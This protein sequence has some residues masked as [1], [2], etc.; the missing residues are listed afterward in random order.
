MLKIRIFALVDTMKKVIAYLLMPRI[1]NVA[2]IE[3]I[4][5]TLVLTLWWL[6][7]PVVGYGDVLE[8]GRYGV[9]AQSAGITDVLMPHVLYMVS[10]ASFWHLLGNI[11]VLWLV[12]GRLFLL[13]ALA[14][15]FVCSWLPGVGSIW[16]IVNNEPVALTVG[17]SGVLFAI[18]GNKWGH[19]CVGQHKGRISRRGR[20]L[21][22]QRTA[23]SAERLKRFCTH[24]LP[25][26][27]IGFFIPHLNW[28]I[29]LYCLTAGFF[30]GMLDG[31]NTKYIKA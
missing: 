12:N 17:F 13:R 11:Y 19:Y 6:F 28:T 2:T 10:H 27:V 14:I 8:G 30:V 20:V 24:V 18:F 31:Y 3:K 15:G 16:E 29:H 21:D 23:I 22:E 26:A 4:A 9:T 5:V 25:F 7:G 1:I